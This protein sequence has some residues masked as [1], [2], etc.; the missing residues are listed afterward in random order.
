MIVLNACFISCV[1]KYDTHWMPIKSY[2]CWVF[3]TDN[4]FSLQCRTKEADI[5]NVELKHH[6]YHLGERKQYLYI[7]AP[8]YIYVF[9]DTITKDCYYRLYKY[10]NYEAHTQSI[11]KIK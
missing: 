3:W 6:H 7:G 2:N 5:F 10:D 8:C 9:Q 11:T 4:H 1:E